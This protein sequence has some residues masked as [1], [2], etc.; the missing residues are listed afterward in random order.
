MAECTTGGRRGARR[1][2][3]VIYKYTI[4]CR[5]FIESLGRTCRHAGPRRPN[6]SFFGDQVC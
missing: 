5:T 3:F 2:S 1:S 4:M 6:G